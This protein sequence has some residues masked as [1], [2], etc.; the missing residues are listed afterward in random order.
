MFVCPFCAAELHIPVDLL[1]AQR[2]PSYTTRFTFWDNG[3][4]GTQLGKFTLWHNGRRAQ[5]LGLIHVPAS[6]VAHNFYRQ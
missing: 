1:V 3:R 2:P 4:R 5:Q 6:G